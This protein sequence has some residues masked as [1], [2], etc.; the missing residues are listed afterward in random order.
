MYYL[1]PLGNPGETYE[2]TRH[3][4]AWLL[5]DAC[6]QTWQLPSLIEDKR[7]AGRSTEGVVSGQPV[8]VLYPTTFMNHSGTAV[9]KTVP[10]DALERLV[11]IYDDVALPFGTIRVAY[12]RGS[13]GHNGV[14]SI[15][16]AVGKGFVRV[17]VGI[18]KDAV[19]TENGNRRP[20]GA[21]LQGYVMGTFTPD[22][23]AALPALAPRLE[24]TLLLIL[25]EGRAV[26]MNRCNVAAE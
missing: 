6:R 19:D 17:R 10:P 13:G 8:T 4:V 15:I 16:D 21:D 26:A 11:V 3:D 18:G 2:H 1:V 12:D 20:S 9:R 14:Q 5:L 24:E 23:L 25:K 22:E 7:R